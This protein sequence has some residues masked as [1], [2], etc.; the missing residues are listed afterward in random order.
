MLFDTVTFWVFFAGA[1]ALWRWLPFRAAKTAIV[2]ASLVFYGWW[3]P[4]YLLL[5]LLSTVT[6]YLVGGRLHR[7]KEPRARRMWLLVSL[8]V[9]L[10]LLA[11]F[12]YAP[13]LVETL[14]PLGGFLGVDPADVLLDDWVTPV[15]ISFY[16][17]QTLSYT[18]DIYRGSLQPCASFRDFFLYVSFFPQLIAGPIVRASE[19]LPQLQRRRRLSPGMVE[20]GFYYIITGLCLKMAI[21]DNLGPVVR[22]AF[23][24]E[25][26]AT[27]APVEVWFGAIAFGTQI[28]SD[29]AGYSRIAIGIAYLMGLRFPRNFCF[30]YISQSLSEFWT[31]WHMTLSRWLRDYLYLP[32]GGNRK[33]RTR[34]YVNLSLT[35]LLGGLWHGAAWTYLAWGAFHGLGLA[36]ERALGWSR[37]AA[38]PTHLIGGLVSGLRMLAVLLFVHTGWVFFRA[39]NMTIATSVLDRMWLAPFDE[40]L[41]LAEFSS[42]R[43]SILLIPI[44]LGHLGQVSRE[45]LGLRLTSN[46][47][48]AVVA[49]SIMMLLV[50][51]RGSG[52]AFLYFQF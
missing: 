23:H 39:E 46:R 47:R 44:F 33:G 37:R 35:M 22:R 18:I 36:I 19:L 2:V 1:W 25:G 41:G 20:A 32:L 38:K 50:L 12:K 6:D 40:G 43:Y 52:R 21:A 27:R 4:E 16:T 45:W 51:S 31:R 26:L 5:I 49:V 28:F 11:F 15:G 10:G 34:T 7:C 3:R 48:A 42:W 17:F 14:S 24:P 9:N 13:L 30:P 8:G 29:F